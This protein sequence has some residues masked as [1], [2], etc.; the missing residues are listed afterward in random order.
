MTI[1]TTSSCPARERR[2]KRPGLCVTKTN[3][4]FIAD[5]R[6]TR[7]RGAGHDHAVPATERERDLNDEHSHPRPQVRPARRHRRRRGPGPLGLRRDRQEGR[8]R[9]RQDRRRRRLP[10]QQPADHGPQRPRRRL[11]HDRPHRGEGHGGREDHRARSRS[12]TSPAP[13]APSACSARSTRR[14]TASSPCRWASASSA[15]PTRRRAKATLNETTPIAKLIEEAGAIVVPEG[16]ALHRTS[17]TLVA[18]WKADPKKVNVGGGSSPGGPDHL[19]PMQLAKAVGIDPKDVSYVGFDGGG[20][21]LPGA[22]RRT[23]SPSAP[24]ASA[25]SSTRSR[26]ARSRSSR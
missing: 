23:R 3:S 19:L 14:A 9:R 20:E 17:T 10:G 1:C 21:L 26:P 5:T 4:T 15:P 22:H 13:V 24:A 12:S 16:L 18:A 11:R 25:S 7:R 8:H 6:A 2:P